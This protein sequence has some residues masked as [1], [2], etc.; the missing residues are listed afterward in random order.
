MLRPGLALLCKF[1]LAVR[2]TPPLNF[3]RNCSPSLMTMV[4]TLIASS[5]GAGWAPQSPS[6]LSHPASFDPSRSSAAL[7]EGKIQIHPD[8]KADDPVMKRWGP[9]AKST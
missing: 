3:L 2:R 1:Y 9:I 8:T 7:W 6:G 4:P 5:I